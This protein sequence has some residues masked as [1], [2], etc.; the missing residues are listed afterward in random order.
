MATSKV[1]PPHSS[2]EKS[3]APSRAVAG[4]MRSRS[5]LRTRVAS[6][7]W[8]ASRMVVSVKRSPFCSRTQAASP[9]GPRA[10]RMSRV[11]GG[12]GEARSTFGTGASRSSLGRSGFWTPGEPLTIT[13]PIQESSFVARSCFRAETSSSGCR[14]MKEVSARPVEEDRVGHHVLEEGDVGLHAA[15]A[16]LLEGAVHDARRLL[17]GEPPG[18]DLHQQRVVVRGDLGPGEAVAGVE[19]DPGA[20]GGAVG[21]DGAEVGGE[22]VLRV[23]GGDAA[24]DGEA[25]HLDV[26]LRG[27]A[28]LRIGE[29]VPLGHQDLGLDQVAAGDHLGDG[30]LHLDARVHLDEVVAPLLVEEELD[31]AGVAVG[32]LAADAAGRPSQSAARCSGVEGQ[33]R[34]ELDHLLVAALHRAVALEEVDEVAVVVAQHLHLDVL[35]ILDVALQEDGRRCRRRPGPRCAP[36]RAPRAAPSGCGPPACRARR[37]RRPP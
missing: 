26:G 11:P 31:G 21:L 8:C 35:G 18:A 30:V 27:D 13:S 36:R 1:A 16:E 32:D 25:A 12:G 15:D 19:P 24:L 23:L 33:R 20:A 17:E 14:S 3:P 10:S 22:V 7:D 9:S 5:W 6:S 29:L 37:R 2:R 28:D 34:G 4:A